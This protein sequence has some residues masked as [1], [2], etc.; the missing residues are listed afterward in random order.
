MHAVIIDD[1]EEYLS[2]HLP[3]WA[4]DRFQAHLETCGECRRE[5]D[6][7]RES[8]GLLRSLKPTVALDPPPGF[9]AQVMQ[10]V[11]EQP[12]PSLWSFLGDFAFGRRVVFAALLM[13]AVLGAVLVSREGAYA[14][15]PT[16]PEAVMADAGGLTNA[17]QMLVTLANYEP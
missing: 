3:P 2:G 10:A 14:P 7:I 1:F 6:E 16:T 4:L 12:V 17:D 11:S 5:V 13:L 9:V 15:N 8:T